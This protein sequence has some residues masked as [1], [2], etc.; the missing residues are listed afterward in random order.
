[1]REKEE[2]RE[3]FCHG[4]FLRPLIWCITVSEQRG[5]DF[6]RDAAALLGFAS[7]TS[8]LFLFNQYV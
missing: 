2:R 5:E 4:V 1:M 6:T 8:L 3:Q 7:E